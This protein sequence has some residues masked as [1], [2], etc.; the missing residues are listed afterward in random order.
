MK[1]RSRINVREKLTPIPIK[2][3][4]DSEGVPSS[5]QLLGNWIE[6]EAVE[7]SFDEGQADDGD[8]AVG[9]AAWSYYRL[10]TVDRSRIHVFKNHFTGQW[11][12]QARRGED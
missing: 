3:V 6:V 7:S 12:H 9:G 8:A 2:V 10:I 11:Y 1:P 5:L 4:E